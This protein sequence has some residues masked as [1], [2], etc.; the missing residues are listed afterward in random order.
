MYILQSRQMNHF[1]MDNDLFYTLFYIYKIMKGNANLVNGKLNPALKK[2]S[3][4]TIT[5][6]GQ[7][8]VQ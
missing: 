7:L 4:V 2:A 8:K 6:Y 3:K 1:C 5:T